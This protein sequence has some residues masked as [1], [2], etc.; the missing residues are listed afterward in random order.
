MDAT[1]KWSHAVLRAAIVLNVPSESL[2]GA[3]ARNRVD[4]TT[5]TRLEVDEFRAILARELK[6]SAAQTKGPQLLGALGALLA[7]R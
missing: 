3:L 4:P 5:I 6:I 2:R 1:D 7:V